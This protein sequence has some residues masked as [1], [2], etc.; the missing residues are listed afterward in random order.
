MSNT[1]VP[2]VDYTSRDYAA[3]RDD[4][5]S[6]I[7][8]FAPEWTNR[9]PADFG[10]TLIELFSY[11]GDMLS[12]YIDR[13]ANEAFISTASQRDNV[14]QLA[15]L[16]SYI[17]TERTAS[18]VTL[19]FQNS[20]ASPITVPALTQVATTTVSS[21]TSTQIIFETNEELIVPAK[22]GTVNGSATVLATQGVTVTNEII[23]ISNGTTSQIFQLAETPVINNSIS[24]TING[25]S[26]SKIPFLIDASSFDPVFSSSTNAAGTTFIV[27][28]DSV[29]GR[30]PPNGATIYATY[31][32]GGGAEGNVASNTIKY[33]LTN[34]TA[35]LTVINQDISVTGDGAATGG[36]DAE[37]TDSIRINAP[38]S[39]RALNRAVSLRDYAELCLQV[40][41]IAKSIAVADVYTSVTVYFAP[42]G[43]KG[44]LIDGVTPSTVFNN[45]KADVLSYLTDRAP[46][47]T[48]ITLQPPSYVPV[49]MN[50]SVTVLPQYKQTPVK[51]AVEETL[52]ALLDFDNVVF[53]D[54][55][56]LQDVMAAI[57]SVSGVAQGAKVSLLVRHDALQKFTVNNKALT[58]NVATLTTS[59]THNFTVGQTV[60]VEDVDST[61][62]GTAV[63]TAVTSTTFSYALIAANVSST[64]VTGGSATALVVGDVVCATNEIP[65]KGTITVTVSGGITA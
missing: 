6:L 53:A 16:L 45:L 41:G 21:A 8:L 33:I 31:R 62:N 35:G 64:A 15:N 29:S 23:G 1:Y 37:S 22:V 3:I 63:V 54:K 61:F 50:I 51:T 25:I 19:T 40:S 38:K 56:T 14:L 4:L 43:D 47:N 26:Y 60:L 36:A 44:V 42:F 52:Y 34:A 18:T 20:T 28:G 24:I 59:A 11:M 57:G 32:T 13:S 58:S 65:E 48:T 17:P 12:Y 5:I 10:I 30:I 7:P 55:I 46:A 39:V 27:F 9:D 49:D 2:Q